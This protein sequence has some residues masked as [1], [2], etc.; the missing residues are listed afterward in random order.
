MRALA[1]KL[2]AFE[3]F[4]KSKRAAQKR[5]LFR[6][7]FDRKKPILLIYTGAAHTISAVRCDKDAG[8]DCGSDNA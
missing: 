7:P 3:A 6:Q 8:R 1:Y 2:H 4:P 5:Q